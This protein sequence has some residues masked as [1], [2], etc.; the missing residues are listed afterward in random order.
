MSANS[1]IDV[2]VLLRRL[3]S[4][5]PTAVTD[6]RLKMEG[7][8][9]DL[10]RRRVQLVFVNNADPILCRQVFRWRNEIF[11]RSER[12]RIEFEVAAMRT[13]WDMQRRYERLFSKAFE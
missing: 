6:L 1:D 10:V 12:A 3:P 8:L 9:E 5:R 13:Y 2:G 4:G 11:C 7:E